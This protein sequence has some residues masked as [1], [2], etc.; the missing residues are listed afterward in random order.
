[1]NI[2]FARLVSA[3][4]LGSILASAVSLSGCDSGK[5]EHTDSSVVVDG[6][7]K[8]ERHPTPGKDALLPFSIGFTLEGRPVILNAK[9]E[10]EQWEVKK[11]PVSTKAVYEI[12]TVTY[13]I[14]QGSCKV[15][16]K[17]GEGIWAEK[18]YPSAL[19]KKWGIP[20]S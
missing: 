7:G 15:M 10:V 13:A 17:V 12:G 18:T 6:S 19:C 2:R 9:G 1:M 16:V 11:L 14:V 4:F 5:E 20:E 3:V 8:D